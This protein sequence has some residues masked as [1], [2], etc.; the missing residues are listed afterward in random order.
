MWRVGV[1]LVTCSYVL[2]SVYIPLGAV[3]GLRRSCCQAYLSY[4]LKHYRKS[5]KK[6][7]TFHIS[8]TFYSLQNFEGFNS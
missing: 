7:A 3:E 8:Q 6:D 5:R 1:F 2:N 4:F